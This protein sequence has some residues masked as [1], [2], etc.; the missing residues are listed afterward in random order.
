MQNKN[1]T[2]YGEGC[3]RQVPGAERLESE[4]F[5]VVNE[6]CYQQKSLVISNVGNGVGLGKHVLS[7]FQVPGS[8][9]DR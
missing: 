7:H 1:A 6:V 4:I 3:W 8:T 9:G 5:N 2:V